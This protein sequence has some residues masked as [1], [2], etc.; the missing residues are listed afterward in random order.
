M[1]KS[2]RLL[3]RDLGMTAQEMNA[4]LKTHGYLEG[5][6]GAYALTDK[7]QV[8]GRE[9]YHSNGVGGHSMYQVNYETRTWS[10]DVVDA[11]RADM[12]AHTDAATGE[13]DLP[14]EDDPAYGVASEDGDTETSWQAAAFGVVLLGAI[15]CAPLA[16]PF[17]ERKVKP[18][19]KRAQAAVARR[20][21]DTRRGKSEH[22]E[23]PDAGLPQA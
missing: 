12:A 15:V 13:P 6:P 10:E 22:G 14:P 7:G 9:R 21:E 3:G 23:L 19:L 2:A 20:R 5:E 8:Y 16:K 11:L 18:R 4:A 1:A 17:Y